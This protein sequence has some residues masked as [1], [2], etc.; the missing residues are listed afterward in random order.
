M[1]ILGVTITNGLSVSPH[2]QSV[3]ASCAQVLYALHVLHAHGLCDSA[4]QTI[5]HSIVIA[6][7]CYA[8]SAWDGFANVTDLNK[9]QP[10]INK[11]KRAGYCSPDL[12]DFENLCTS[13]KDDL[14]N[15]ILNIP[16]HVLH[17]LLPSPNSIQPYSLRTRAHNRTLPQRKSHLVDCNFLIRMLYL[18]AF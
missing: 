1:K 12:P 15:K 3:I 7:L 4:L 17:P 10:F 18:N 6:K 14:F 9:I 11:S 16:T 5:Y 8:S 2:A 13:M